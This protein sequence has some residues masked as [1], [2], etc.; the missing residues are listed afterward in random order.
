M[1]VN[2]DTYEF[3]YDID[4][5]G[6]KKMCK[7]RL[8]RNGDPY[9]TLTMPLVMG[10]KELIPAFDE[11]F[12][13][14][15]KDMFTT[16]SAMAN[17]DPVMIYGPT[18]CGKTT[19]IFQVASILEWPVISIDCTGQTSVEDLLGTWMIAP[20]PK[21]G[22]QI[23][24]WKDGDA[25][26][27]YRNGY[28]LVLNEFDMLKPE[29]AAIL[30]DSLL[31]KMRLFK[32]SSTN[33]KGEIAEEIV[34][35]HPNFRLIATCNSRGYGDDDAIY[36]GIEY[37]NAATL[38]RFPVKLKMDYV[39]PETE[40]C[41]LTDKTNIEE[42][43]AQRMVDFGVKARALFNKRETRTMVSTFRLIKWAEYTK[44]LGPEL[45]YEMVIQ[46]HAAKNDSAT[47]SQIYSR[48]FH[49]EAIDME[50]IELQRIMDEMPCFGKDYN[51]NDQLCGEC[52][53]KE[54]CRNRCEK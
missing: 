23:M 8:L 17:R 30:N 52:E 28:I 3:E 14:P 4:S 54:Q 38:E 45:G 12:Y 37:L 18:Q 9:Q 6:K 16:M 22:G 27:A 15:N 53:Y 24:L 34:K 39:D 43:M 50:K 35:E 46:N 36:E 48:I 42:V 19:M 47:L 40:V 5:K 11:N 10:K 2:L 29:I 1:E 13:M 33:S 49:T 32:T 21:G 26:E 7:M 25:M 51:T 41:V 20:N 31:A 44:D